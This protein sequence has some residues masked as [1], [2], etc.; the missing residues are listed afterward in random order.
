[1]RGAPPNAKTIE[2]V[3]AEDPLL[4]FLER[5]NPSYQ[6]GQNYNDPEGSAYGV[7]KM[8]GRLTRGPSGEKQRRSWVRQSGKVR[9]KACF[10]RSLERA[11]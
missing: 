1:M 11:E 6:I 2:R 4:T 7:E 10:R 5:S 3:P 8:A 9:P